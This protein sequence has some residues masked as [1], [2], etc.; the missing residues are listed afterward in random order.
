MVVLVVLLL[1]LLEDGDLGTEQMAFALF[2]GI[3]EMQ[4]W[5]VKELLPPWNLELRVRSSRRSPGS[6]V[7]SLS[8]IYSLF[9]L[10]KIS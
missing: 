9:C 7:S 3:S 6:E 8:F 5:G 4:V 10:C 2:S 1:L